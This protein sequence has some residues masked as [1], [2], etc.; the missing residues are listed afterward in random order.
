[1][2]TPMQSL[3]VKGS[4]G[5]PLPP[6]FEALEMKGTRFL[7]GQLGLVCAGPGTGKSAFVLTYALKARVPTLYFSADSDAFTQLSRMVSIQTAW[8]MEKSARAVRNSDLAEVAAEFEDI[9]IR[10]NY[11]ASPSLDQI[12]DSMKAYCQGYGDYPDLVVVDNITNVRS[13]GGEDDD[14]FSGLESMMDYL[15]TMARNTGACVVGLHHVTGSYN[16]AD[17]PI[18][19]SGVKGQITRVPELVLTL[20][21]VSEEFGPEALRVSTVKNRAGRMDPSGL[22]FVELE[23]IGDTMQ[24][25][26]PSNQ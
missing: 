6:V 25:R 5:D 21:R 13:G 22:D 9:P 4:A 1:M 14:P 8:S 12:E 24:I 15:H 11:N 16:D 3:R 19:L 18:P 23:F 20:H 2:Y 17:K 7:R 26:D 10:F